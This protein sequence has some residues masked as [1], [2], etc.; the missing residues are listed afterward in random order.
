MDARTGQ[1][2]PC[3][4][5]GSTNVWWRGRRWYDV[6]LTWL[7]YIIVAPIEM[8]FG[9][10]QRASGGIGHTAHHISY[11]AARDAYDDRMSV[12]TGRWFWRCGSCGERGQV[13]ED[14][15]QAQIEHISSIEADM[16]ENQ[17][18]A[19]QPFSRRHD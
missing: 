13:F 5:C 18:G 1:T 4:M 15:G 3:P 19:E 6:P 12:A 14:I 11:E 16:A 9:T 2:D 8:V 10:K 7:R 17:G